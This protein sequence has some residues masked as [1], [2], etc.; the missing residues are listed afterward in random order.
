[1]TKN[2]SIARRAFA[3]VLMGGLMAAS[4]VAQ[5]PKRLIAY[6]HSGGLKATPRY[7]ADQIPYRK[8]THL[9]H[10]VVLPS[11]AADGTVEAIE[12]A[13]EPALVPKA[14]SAGV[15][16]LVCV[17]G[18]AGSFSRVA[19]DEGSRKRFGESLRE[20]VDKHGYDGVDIDWEVPQG[21]ADVANCTKLMQAVRAALPAPRYLLSM[22]TPSTPGHWGEFDFPGLTP[23]LDFYNV[24]TYDFH[25]PWTNH[26]GHNSP[27]F[28]SSSDTG[29]DGSLDDSVNLYLNQFGVP[30]E[31]INLG[32]AFYGYEFPV[33]GLS[34]EC[35]CEKTT[36]SRKYGPEIK[37][38]LNRGG[39]IRESDQGKWVR[40]FDPVAMAPYLVHDSDPAVFLTY[41]DPES[42]ARKVVYALQVRDLGG[43]FMWEL[44]QDYDGASQDLL[45]AMYAAFQRSA[46][47]SG[48]H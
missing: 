47:M 1:M 25:G 35:N 3:L 27:L 11:K 4:A 18:A 26:T 21:A 17:Q 36:V 5:A 12:D 20:F 44:S 40:H 29:H 41:D 31:K 28:S 22:A 2:G 33:A 39:R 38:H 8:L 24:M 16:V 10:V 7:S 19:A 46:A 45:D 15:K 34:A 23:L 37:P 32:T 30:P 6:Y 43:V 13:L 14:H 42:T 48:S 9:I